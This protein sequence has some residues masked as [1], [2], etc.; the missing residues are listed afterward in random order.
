[1]EQH[2]QQGGPSQHVLVNHMTMLGRTKK[3]WNLEGGDSS[4]SSDDMNSAP[5]SG[6]SSEGEVGAATGADLPYSSGGA[7]LPAPAGSARR[8]ESRNGM[9]QLVAAAVLGRISGV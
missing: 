9:R 5:I 6:S 4:S 7:L 1:V 2:W 3:L 8:P